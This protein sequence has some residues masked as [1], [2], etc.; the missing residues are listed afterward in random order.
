MDNTRNQTLI[1]KLLWILSILHS[2][3]HQLLCPLLLSLDNRLKNL[4]P[5]LILRDSCGG[6]AATAYRCFQAL[7]VHLT[8]YHSKLMLIHSLNIA[9]I[10]IRL[11][12]QQIRSIYRMHQQIL[13]RICNRH[14]QTV[15]NSHCHK[16]TINKGSLR[17]TKGNVRKTTGCRNTK[18]VLTVTDRLQCLHC[19]HFIGSNG[20]HQSVHDHILRCQPIFCRGL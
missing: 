9:Q 8:T 1:Y 13:G 19:C 10:R 11:V 20:C 3:L 4:I 15:H 6:L 14:G 7:A 17:Q 5:L 18:L 12:H 2:L 16:V